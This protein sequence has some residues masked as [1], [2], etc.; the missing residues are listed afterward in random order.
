[1][2]WLLALA[3]TIGGAG[4][5]ASAVAAVV[6]PPL[7]A[8]RDGTNR[9][10][11]FYPAMYAARSVPLGLMVAVVVW[12]APTPLTPLV[13][14]AAAL[15]QVADAAIGASYRITGM[16]IGPAIAAACH[17]AGALALL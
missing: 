14:A 9:D 11:R 2:P 8:P 4:S 12:L 3:N 13:L 10:D 16:M 1:M 6:R 17:A 7:L 15:A 5:A